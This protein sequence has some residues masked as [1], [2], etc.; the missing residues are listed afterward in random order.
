MFGV[1]LDTNVVTCV[2]GGF[3]DD[4]EAERSISEDRQLPGESEGDIVPLD[5]YFGK[6]GLT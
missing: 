2:T 3:V 4:D 1:S 5:K 6:D